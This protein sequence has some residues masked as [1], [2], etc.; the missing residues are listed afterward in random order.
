MGIGWQQLLVLM[1]GGFCVLVIP[2]AIVGLVVFLVTK[3]NRS[4]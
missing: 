4:Q 1:M 2:I 3:K